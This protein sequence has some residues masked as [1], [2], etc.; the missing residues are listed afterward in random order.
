MKQRGGW[1]YVCGMAIRNQVELIHRYLGLSQ[2]FFLRSRSA[3]A[4]KW[5]L[6]VKFQVWRWSDKS[7]VL[8]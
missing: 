1:A 8:S 2:V 5:N 4:S 7:T 3:H 6:F